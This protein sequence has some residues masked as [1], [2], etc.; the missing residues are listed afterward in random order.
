MVGVGGEMICP[1]EWS[2]APP[3]KAGWYWAK[4]DPKRQTG[5]RVHCVEVDAWG[6]DEFVAWVVACDSYIPVNYF[7]CWLGPIDVPE[8]PK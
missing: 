5:A 4:D 2:T 7:T 8:A 6:G 1:G 3:T